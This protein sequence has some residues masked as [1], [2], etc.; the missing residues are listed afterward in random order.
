M[1][2]TGGDAVDGLEANSAPP[3]AVG[4]NN[5]GLELATARTLRFLATFVSTWSEV[6]ARNEL[7]CASLPQ[8]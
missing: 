7:R 2:E 3:D 1:Y 5:G 8:G 6:C 4:E